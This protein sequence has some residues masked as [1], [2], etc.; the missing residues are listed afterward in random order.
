MT[1]SLILTESTIRIYSHSV[2]DCLPRQ[3]SHC[4]SHLSHR[5][6]PFTPTWVYAC[7][8]HSPYIPEILH[9]LQKGDQVWL[10]DHKTCSSEKGIFVVLEIHQFPIQY[11]FRRE[12]NAWLNVKKAQRMISP[13]TNPPP[14][15]LLKVPI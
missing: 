15:T 10:R 12:E 3:V 14:N 11:V 5:L 9:L 6:H 2:S 7:C 4:A 13:N 1:F 8:L